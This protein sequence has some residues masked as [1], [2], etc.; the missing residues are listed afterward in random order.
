MSNVNLIIANDDS[1]SLQG[2]AGSDLIYGYDPNE[3]QKPS[4]RQLA[5]GVAMG[6]TLPLFASA[7]RKLVDDC[8]H[9]VRQIGD[10]RN[11]VWV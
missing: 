10:S 11:R 1:N 7:A 9:S 4:Q 8:P 2:T 3:A 6:F 5:T